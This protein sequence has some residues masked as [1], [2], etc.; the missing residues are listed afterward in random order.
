[1]GDTP[2]FRSVKMGV[3][4]LVGG[5]I[6]SLITSGMYANPLAVYREYL[7]NAAD[8]I[9]GSGY[10][11]KGR[12]EIS[13]EPAAMAVAIRDNG[14]GLSCEQA[15]R[16][17]LPVSRSN[18]QRQADRGFRG[19]GRLAGLAFGRSVKFLTRHSAASPVT[20]VTWDGDR[21]RNGIHE[22]LPVEDIIRQCVTVEKLDGNDYPES[23]F[24]VRVEEIARHA[25][26]LL[27]NRDVVRQYLGEV[28]PVPFNESFPYAG[29]ISDMFEEVPPLA[30]DVRFMEGETPIIRPHGSALCFS[31]DRLSPFSGFEKIEIP[32]LGSADHA[33]TGWIAHSSYLG[34]LPP[35]PGIR[36][37]RA[38]VGNI[39]IGDETVFDH[40]FSETRFNRWCVA[41]IHILDPRIMPNARRDYFEPGPH[42]RNL[43]NHLGVVCR[44][45]ENRCRTA[46][47]RRNQRRQYQPFLEGLEAAY[48]LA[49]SNCLPARVAQELMR[50]KLSELA[51]FREKYGE[52][53]DD[54]E[55][56][57]LAQI[58][59]KLVRFQT[60]RSGN[61]K[62]FSGINSSYAPVCRKI[63][64]ILIENSSSPQAAKE[65]IE[66]IL[67]NLE[68]GKG[69]GRKKT[70]LSKARTVQ[71]KPLRR[72]GS[73]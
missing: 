7:Q 42:L 27:L 6:L 71:K 50:G 20:T 66:T 5:D 14:P 11:R 9:A 28:C 69:H 63:F 48:E 39:Q 67:R 31:R 36:C 13:I 57:R 1:M 59:K 34:A 61:G 15:R 44:Q 12:V 73:L 25:A 33:A 62:L 52:V 22:K 68:K 65:I 58:E 32:A 23:F 40:L 47:R 60:S 24:E 43:E 8:S 72:A 16:S 49:G 45:L 19:I 54:D 10:S 70:A 2:V 53:I 26:G 3:D 30:L 21:L 29:Q 41:E 55:L 46:S 18:K 37:L 17:L 64:G 51:G 35:K 56:E 38:R 4:A